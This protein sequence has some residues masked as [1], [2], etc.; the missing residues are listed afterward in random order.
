MVIQNHYIQKKEKTH[1][2]THT[3]TTPVSTLKELGERTTINPIYVGCQTPRKALSNTE[4]KG[5][6]KK[7]NSCEALPDSEG[8]TTQNRQNKNTT[9]KRQNNQ[10][11]VN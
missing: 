3:C 7:R 2:H 10:S 5:K 11:Q 1:K 6:Q 8:R 9:Q 4:R